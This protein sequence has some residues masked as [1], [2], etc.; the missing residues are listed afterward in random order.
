MPLALGIL[1]HPPLAIAPFP[2][3]SLPNNAPDVYKLITQ[4]STDI[5]AFSAPKMSSSSPDLQPEVMNSSQPSIASF[6]IADVPITS[7]APTPT[8]STPSLSIE[9][10]NTLNLSSTPATL[11]LS[12]SLINGHPLSDHSDKEPKARRIEFKRLLQFPAQAVQ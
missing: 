10:P 3:L 7:G 2:I 12:G 5:V 9:I 11:K 6:S 4:E 1:E 8:P